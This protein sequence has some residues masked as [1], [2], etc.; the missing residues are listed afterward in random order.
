MVQAHELDGGVQVIA[1]G[2]AFLVLGVV[3][4]GAIA[5]FVPATVFAKIMPS[6]PVLAKAVCQG[7]MWSSLEA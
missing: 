1:P 7:T 5:A 3:V 4:S 6:S 2:E